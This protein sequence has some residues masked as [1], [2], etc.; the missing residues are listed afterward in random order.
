MKFWDA[1]A[2]PL[3]QRPTSLEIVTHDDRLAAAARK[4]GFSVIDAA[5]G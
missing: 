2:M 4:E 5:A 1:S 3:E